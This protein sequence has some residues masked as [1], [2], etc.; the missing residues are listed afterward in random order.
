MRV[1][2]GGWLD[3]PAPGEFPGQGTAVAAVFVGKF[4]QRFLARDPG[5]EQSESRGVL[6]GGLGGSG[7]AVSAVGASPPGGSF[8]GGAVFLG[9]V[10]AYGAAWSVGCHGEISNRWHLPDWW[11][12][13][14]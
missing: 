11:F 13:V 10:A 6:V 7:E 9:G 8:G 14:G 3:P 4:R 12:G 2:G 1:W 5:D